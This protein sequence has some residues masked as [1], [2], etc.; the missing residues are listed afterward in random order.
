VPAER[1]A[2]G[3]VMLSGAGIPL[4]E[5]SL[6][7]F[8]RAFGTDFS[9]VR[10]H[11]DGMAG[12]A[13][14]R[15]DAEA[16]TSGNHVVLGAGRFAPG[17][18]TG[19][20]LLAH[21]LA[22]VVQQRGAAPSAVFSGDDQ[23]AETQAQRAADQVIS[24]A[25]PSGLG[26]R[27]SGVARSPRR[28]GVT[29]VEINCAD[30][31][32]HFNGPTAHTWQLSEC[33]LSDGDY[34][35]T[36]E[37]QRA[38]TTV[39]RFRLHN[40]PE[41]T[42][43]R[44]GYQIMGSEANPYDM[45]QEG[46]SVRIHATSASTTANQAGGAATEQRRVEFHVAVVD[47]AT[48]EAATGRSVAQLPEGRLQTGGFRLGVPGAG[49]GLL[50]TPRFVQSA[51]PVVDPWAGTFSDRWAGG[52]AEAAEAA[53]RANAARTGGFV[54]SWA[55]DPASQNAWRG[56]RM[57]HLSPQ[58]MT[59]LEDVLN[60][61]SV[62]LGRSINVRNQGALV[63]DD[64]LVARRIPWTQRWQDVY[65]R[66]LY[67]RT[68]TGIPV[69]VLAGG[70]YTSGEVGAAEAGARAAGINNRPFWWEGTPRPS[71]VGPLLPAAP[72]ST[73][74]RARLGLANVPTGEI[75]RG[76]LRAARHVLLVYGAYSSVT[77]IA[78]AP[79]SQ[80]AVVA[81]EE[82]GSWIGGWAGAALASALGGAVVCAET[83]PGA[84]VCGAAFGIVG[85]ITGSVVGAD[86]AQD[87]AQGAQNVRNRLLGDPY[88]LNEA[89]VQMF[90]ERRRQYYQDR[91]LLES[92]G[93]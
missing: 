85:G 24:N 4:P 76:V 79:E 68:S 70:G 13:A 26:S 83:G 2:T 37:L 21:E 44:F 20:R 54:P 73:G 56:I 22:H 19:D 72:P 3:T 69:D 11:T 39:V 65:N 32:I 89:A 38:P 88:R 33:D 43:F 12:Q 7:R 53:T 82:G 90:D 5:P 34:T 9:N 18:A 52:G 63:L 42:R 92:L 51:A 66:A 6:V 80:R 55:L 46:Q 10:L 1:T 87:I 35:A 31:T 36:V 49:F 67:A 62:T 8:E 28:G 25:R 61:P 50:N 47:T 29:A 71:E 60:A 15:F 27:P 57:A 84:L 78:D 91:E 23:T 77:R 40:A 58:E 86:L 64:W 41:G 14:D 45:V 17:T 48:Y 30:R 93:L 74:V 81:A 75:V 16:W 59:L